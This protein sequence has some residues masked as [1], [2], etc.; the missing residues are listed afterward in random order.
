MSE[1]TDLFTTGAARVSGLSGVR[2]QQTSLTPDTCRLTPVS[3]G[4]S[5]VGLGSLANEVSRV[6]TTWN[7]NS[8][9]FPHDKGFGA[10]GN[11]NP[12]GAW[13]WRGSKHRTL[14]G[15]AHSTSA[16]K[17]ACVDAGL[18]PWLKRDHRAAIERPCAFHRLSHSR[19][20][21]SPAKGAVYDPR[22]RRR[23]GE[24]ERSTIEFCQP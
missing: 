7:S 18:S 24:F 9:S 6:F 2:C 14:N 4:T 21:P 16:R 10:V 12:S 8:P 3:R 11:K 20:R 1:V 13:L 22:S 23:Q 5:D 19:G 15:S 17:R